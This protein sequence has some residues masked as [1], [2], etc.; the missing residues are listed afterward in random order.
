MDYGLH[1][2]L[3]ER[4]RNKGSVTFGKFGSGPKGSVSQG[5][6]RDKPGNVPR[7]SRPRPQPDSMP[8]EENGDHSI[9]G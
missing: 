1:L 4:D 3:S 6:Q 7:I 5:S 8:H 2:T 9:Q